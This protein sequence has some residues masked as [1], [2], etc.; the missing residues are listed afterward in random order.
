MKKNGRAFHFN[1]F[2]IAPR[3]PLATVASYFG[4]NTPLP[5]ENHLV[6]KGSRLET[7]L[8]YQNTSKQV[9]LFDF[10]CLTF[11][12]FDA[13]EIRVFL[14]YLRSITGKVDNNLFA[15]F[16]EGHTLYIGEKKLCKLWKDAEEA[17]A[18]DESILSIVAMILAKSVAL[19]KIE[20]D[21]AELLD[22]AEGLLLSLQ[23]GKLPPGARKFS[24]VIGSMLRFQYDTIYSVKIFDRP[25]SIDCRVWSR[26]IYD[27]LAGYYELYDRFDI[28]NS[29]MDDLKTITSSY[30]MLTH[31]HNERRLLLFE[32][33]LLALFPLFHIADILR[34]LLP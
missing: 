12:N 20:K 29:K 3:L 8:K 25:A 4:L 26:D 10:G 34:S 14:D 22:Q 23:K 32:I 15:S 18:Y 16:H 2:K 19:S 24:K 31:N 33:F 11:V 9:Y 7:I 13:Q 28:V 1:C 6:L 5:W 17:V 27:S 30:S 21:V